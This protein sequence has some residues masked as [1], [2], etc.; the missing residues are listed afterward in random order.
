MDANGDGKVSFDECSF[1][2]RESNDRQQTNFHF[3]AN[4]SPSRRAMHLSFFLHATQKGSSSMS[5]A[6]S[7]TAHNQIRQ[8]G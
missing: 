7:S 4:N 2:G 1:T 6:H 5:Q 8:G 3:E